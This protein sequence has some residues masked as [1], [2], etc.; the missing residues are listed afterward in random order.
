MHFSTTLA[1]SNLSLSYQSKFDVVLVFGEL[2]FCYIEVS[3]LVTLVEY[4][5]KYK[6]IEL[7]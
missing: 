6:M 7:Y 4:V 3:I 2:L 1:R 5:I